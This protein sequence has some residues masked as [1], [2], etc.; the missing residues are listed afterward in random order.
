M[1]VL[2]SLIISFTGE[3][4]PLNQS[5][6]Y[7]ASQLLETALKSCRPPLVLVRSYDAALFMNSFGFSLRWFRN[8]GSLVMGFGQTIH[9]DIAAQPSL[10]VRLSII[11]ILASFFISQ[12]TYR[13]SDT[14]GIYT[15]LRRIPLSHV[16]ILTF[17][18]LFS[19]LYLSHYF[20]VTPLIGF[21]S[22][23]EG[24][25]LLQQ[26]R[27]CPAIPR[28]RSSSHQHVRCCNTWP[29]PEAIGVFLYWRHRPYQCKEIYPISRP[30]NFFQDVGRT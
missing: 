21:G 28:G 11:I 22:R 16:I 6:N 3:E 5:G 23:R 12:R 24:R 19:F 30:A 29:A 15:R 26:D 13:P 18:S 7:S 2:K 9:G 20:G 10:I 4:L 17:M 1:H 25:L 14:S 27:C 8:N